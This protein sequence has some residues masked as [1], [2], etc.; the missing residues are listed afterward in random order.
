MDLVAREEVKLMGDSEADKFLTREY[1][2]RR[3][4]QWGDGRVI[5]SGIYFPAIRAMQC[6]DGFRFSMQAGEMHYCS[7]RKWNPD[8]WQLWEVGFP[9]EPEPLLVP[10][11]EMADNLKETVYAMVPSL[12]IAKVI[13][14]HGGLMGMDPL[15]ELR[16][17][18]TER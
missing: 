14:N 6:Y 2:R 18:V 5:A 7:P 12:V 17:T 16:N 3:K 8:V 9:S 13:R 11:A 1:K 15:D 10:Y 4:E